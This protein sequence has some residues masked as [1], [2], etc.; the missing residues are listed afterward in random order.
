MEVQ[1]Y[2]R[3]LFLIWILELYLIYEFMDLAFSSRLM[4]PLYMYYSF[5]FISS[6]TTIYSFHFTFKLVFFSSNFQDK[7]SQYLIVQIV[8]QIIKVP[9]HIVLIRRGIVYCVEILTSQVSQ[10]YHLP[11]CTQTPV[12]TQL[13]VEALKL[14]SKTCSLAALCQAFIDCTN[15]YRTYL[16]FL[17]YVLAYNKYI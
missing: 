8:I 14:L 12:S 9:V 16:F 5:Q 11:F 17:I 15:A 1:R 4:V 7:M 6:F 3:R 2:G 10:H 13:F